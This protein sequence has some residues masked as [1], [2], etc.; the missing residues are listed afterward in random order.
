MSLSS[1][2]ISWEIRAVVFPAGFK[3]ARLESRSSC[4]VRDKSVSCIFY[5]PGG[6]VLTPVYFG[7]RRIRRKRTRAAELGRNFQTISCNNFCMQN[8][9]NTFSRRTRRALYVMQRAASSVLPFSH[10]FFSLSLSLS[11]SLPRISFSFSH[12][13]QWLLSWSQ[14]FL[15]FFVLFEILAPVFFPIQF[16]SFPTIVLLVFTYSYFNRKVV[17]TNASLAITGIHQRVVYCYIFIKMH[18][19]DLRSGLFKKIESFT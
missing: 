2:Q 11:F 13:W 5:K 9:N 12:Q 10:F 6:K 16:S 8:C 19:F 15:F 17:I 4:G 18:L 14:F 3:V 1:R 7:K